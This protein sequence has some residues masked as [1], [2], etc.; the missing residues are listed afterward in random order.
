LVRL[1]AL[2]FSIIGDRPYG[3]HL[4][5]YCVYIIDRWFKEIGML[6][7]A[8]SFLGHP[9]VLVSLVLILF[10]LLWK[11]PWSKLGQA[12]SKAETQQQADQLKQK[13]LLRTL[14]LEQLK[15]KDPESTTFRNEVLSKENV[16]CGEYN[17]K[18][19]YGGYVGYQRFIV[20][21]GKFV[22]TE[23]RGMIALAGANEFSKTIASAEKVWRE[24]YSAEAVIKKENFDRRWAIYCI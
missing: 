18:N 19:S 17:S 9:A 14:V 20:E 5:N 7:K 11:Q 21:D 8:I 15:L 16:L 24:L 10:S 12:A 13:L 1:W 23:L 3:K 2:V 22:D 4:K 6:S